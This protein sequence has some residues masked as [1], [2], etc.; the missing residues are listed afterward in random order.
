MNQR[1]ISPTGLDIC[2]DGGSLAA[3]FLDSEGIELTLFFPVRLCVE[4]GRRFE[5][6]GYFSPQIEW[7]VRAPRISHV[8]GLESIDTTK[9]TRAISWEEARR[10]LSELAPQIDQLKTEYA[11]VFPLMNEAAENDG[12]LSGSA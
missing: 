12:Q 1:A 3:S 7:F 8:T 10:I 5:R 11:Y 6:V 2:R 9:E 4:S